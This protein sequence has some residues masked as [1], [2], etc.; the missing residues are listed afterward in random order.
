[1]FFVG[2][3]WNFVIKYIKNDN[4]FYVRLRVRV[5]QICNICNIFTF[6]FDF[7]VHR[8]PPHSLFINLTTVTVEC[9]CGAV[10]FRPVQYWSLLNWRNFRFRC[11][12]IAVVVIWCFVFI[13]SFLAIFKNFVHSSKQCATFLNNANYLKTVRC[14]CIFFFNLLKPV[15]YF[16]LSVVPTLRWI[17]V[18]C[19]PGS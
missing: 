8:G 14:G 4:T 18:T 6:K 10:K 15:L 5:H 19:S 2:F 3:K 11:G 7:I 12:S 13:S 17:F 1:M 16:R 9:I